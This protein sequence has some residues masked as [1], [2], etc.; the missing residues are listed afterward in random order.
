M[1]IARIRIHRHVRDHDQS[2]DGTFKRPHR[3]LEQSCGIDR[4]ASAVVLAGLSQGRK[5]GHGRNA[6]G[7]GLGGGLS[8]AGDAHARTSRH[9]CDRE[10][11]CVRV[12]K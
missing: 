6:Q 5:Q 10:I 12:D 3:L 9:G 7:I 2:G 8:Q 1:S 11:G 4:F